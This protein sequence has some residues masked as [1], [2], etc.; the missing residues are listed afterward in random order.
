M[1]NENLKKL[2]P[3]DSESY[4]ISN[5]KLIG[6][7]GSD[8]YDYL[9]SKGLIQLSHTYKDTPYRWVFGKSGGNCLDYIIYHLEKRQAEQ[10]MSI[11]D[12]LGMRELSLNEI[13]FEKIGSNPYLNDI[14]EKR[15]RFG[16]IILNKHDDLPTDY[17]STIF[18]S[19]IWHTDK[20][21]Q[22]NNYKLLIYLNDI[23]ENQGGLVVADP[24]VSPKR[25][26]GKCALFNHH[27]VNVSDITYTEV[28][29]GRGTTASFNSHIL[30]RANLPKIGYRHCLHLSFLLPGENYKH[31]K[32]SNNHYG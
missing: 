16:D 5:D 20:T 32:Y 30:H 22:L 6:D 4:R 23:S 7:I 29:G 19:A 11:I 3:S 14:E 26:D 13:K 9:E 27:K 28:I 18:Y 10:F 1:I 2:I 21:F 12:H 17:N 25:I 15:T 31:S 8:L 24:I